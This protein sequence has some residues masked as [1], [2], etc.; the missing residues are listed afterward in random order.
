MTARSRVRKWRM[1]LLPIRWGGSATGV[2]I[3]D[4]CRGP[5]GDR[6]IICFCTQEGES[7]LVTQPD[8]FRRTRVRF[9][10]ETALHPE[11]Q[12]QNRAGR[13][14]QRAC[15]EQHLGPVVPRHDGIVDRGYLGTVI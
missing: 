12:D 7:K 14:G 9:T 1:A 6:F 5:L 3:T 2:L 13:H 11:Q 15:K 10:S 8:I 4:K